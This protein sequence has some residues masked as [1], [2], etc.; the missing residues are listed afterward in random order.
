VERV[1]SHPWISGVINKDQTREGD[2]FDA[3]ESPGW[4]VVSI[5]LGAERGDWRGS[6]PD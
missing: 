4:T 5:V 6:R 1:A 3:Q 2:L